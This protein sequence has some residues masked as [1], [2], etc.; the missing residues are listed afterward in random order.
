MDRKIFEECGR[1]FAD[2]VAASLADHEKKRRKTPE[3]IDRKALLKWLRD[4]QL[5]NFA[6][7]GY[8]REYNFIE[9]LI[10]GIE[11]EPTVESAPVVHGHWIKQ[12]PNEEA[13]NAFH[14]M[15]IGKGMS[16][17]SIYW[18]CS[19]CGG[20]GTPTHKFC[21]NC[22]A[23]MRKEKKMFKVGQ[24]IWCIDQFNDDLE[25]AEVSGYLFMAECGNY[26]IASCEYAHWEDD[27]ENQ[28]EEMYEESMEYHGVELFMLKKDLCFETQS[29]AEDFLNEMKMDYR[30]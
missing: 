3:L 21:N 15:G 6:R 27:F 11:N 24:W 16:A 26:I 4:Y 5:E 13:M 18:T 12:K 28:L 20:W 8:E 19:E 29:Q 23:D 7:F 9:N 30:M 2:G 22:G 10:K 1:A 14:A 17:K 25:D